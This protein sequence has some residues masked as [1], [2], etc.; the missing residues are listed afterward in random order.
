MSPSAQT[1]RSSSY[2]QP[3]TAAAAEIPKST[4]PK[5]DSRN[6]PFISPA[7]LQQL[8]RA[9]PS[10]HTPTK[11]FRSQPH[12]ML[13]SSSTLTSSSQ[14]TGPS[15]PAPPP[16]PPAHGR[17]T[18]FFSTFL[19]SR[20]SSNAEPVQSHHQH[21]QSLLVGRAATQRAG[22]DELGRIPT[23]D[24]PPPQPDIQPT[25]SRSSI[26]RRPTTQQ[27]PAAPLHPEIRSVVGL[28][29]AHAHKIYHSGP[30][31]RRIERLPDGHRPTKDE[32]WRE[33]W[34]QLGGTTFS[35][36]DMKEIEDARQ[37]GTE[38]PPTYINITDAVSLSFAFC[39]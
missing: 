3:Q 12:D 7:Q 9:D 32:G 5:W 14:H 8:R 13:A 33:V 2:G 21:S 11:D 16:K 22:T 31:V 26:D 29:V 27:Q 36:W 24:N 38:V 19:G 1:N 6:R 25:P 4:S 28:T 37:R 30:L 17:S 34:G 18:S 10:P 20:S 23:R 35:I 15:S 39:G